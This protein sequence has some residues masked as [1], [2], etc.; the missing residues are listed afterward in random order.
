MEVK[1][2]TAPS[3]SSI[4]DLPTKE[5][6]PD[7]WTADESGLPH[8]NPEL[9]KLI[10][11]YIE[12]E[13]KMFGLD[14]WAVHIYG[15]SATF[16]WAPGADIDVSIFAKYDEK[17]Y[18]SLKDYFKQIHIPYKE[19]EIHFFLKPQ[20]ASIHEAADASYD[21]L[22]D[23]WIVKPERPEDGDPFELYPELLEYAEYTA[24]KIDVKLSEFD[25]KLAIY[26]RTKKQQPHVNDDNDYHHRLKKLEI[27]LDRLE[28][29]IDGAI[30]SLRSARDDYH[31]K[32]IDQIHPNRIVFEEVVYKYLDMTGVNQHQY[33]SLKEYEE[34][35]S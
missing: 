34:L 23:C 22:S 33:E 19:F 16:Q 13:A 15:G 3:L 30:Q 5:L 32:I 28:F 26:K 31:K 8:L 10:I 35:K 4:L 21:V 14:V 25:R 20:G 11:D 9:R 17:E 18:E 12:Q 29:E 2:S 7:V 6:P 27:E 24:T 1:R